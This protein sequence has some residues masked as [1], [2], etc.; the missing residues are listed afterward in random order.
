MNSLSRNVCLWMKFSDCKFA[1]L[2][3]QSVCIYSMSV[4][5]LTLDKKLLLRQKKKGVKQI[6]HKKSHESPSPLVNHSKPFSHAIPVDNHKLS[7]FSSVV[8][9]K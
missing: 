5:H 6:T 7:C 3:P 9:A 2:L 8:I 1:C 4:S